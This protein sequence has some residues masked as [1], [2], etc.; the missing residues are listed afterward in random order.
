[1]TAHDFASGRSAPDVR[2]LERSLIADELAID[3]EA[4]ARAALALRPTFTLAIPG[5]S[6][7]TLCF[8]RLARLGLDWSRVDVFQVDERAVPVDDSESNFGRA[9]TLW[10]YPAGFPHA[11]IHRMRADSPD[12]ADAARDYAHELETV[13]GEPPRLDYVL[14]GVGPDGHVGSLFPGHPALH[15][16]RTVLAIKGAPKPPTHRITLSMPVLL[17]ASRVAIVAYG[18]EKAAVIHAALHDP[19]SDL[20]VARVAQRSQRCLVL[21]DPAAGAGSRI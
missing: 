18:E 1:M 8:P 6:V 13:A 2:V 14:L 16:H 5:G 9:K 10:L 15:D 20:P 19:D 12:L 4:E 7:A 11:R 21:I 3:L 17:N